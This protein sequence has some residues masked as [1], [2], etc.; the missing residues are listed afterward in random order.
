MRILPQELENNIKNHVALGPKHADKIRRSQRGE[1]IYDIF[2]PL[3][4]S[5]EINSEPKNVEIIKMLMT[6]THFK[7]QKILI[8]IWIFIS[9]IQSCHIAL[10]IQQNSKSIKTIASQYKRIVLQYFPIGC[11]QILFINLFTPF[12]IWVFPS[13]D[14]ARGFKILNF[15]VEFEKLEINEM[16]CMLSRNRLRFAYIWLEQTEILNIYSK[17][18]YISAPPETSCCVRS[19]FHHLLLIVNLKHSR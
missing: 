14:R 17:F 13:K 11:Y 8:S 6:W 19:F 9:I 1:L 5:E 3:I 18:Y 12:T 2:F 7:I 15:N 4:A 16:L 10:I